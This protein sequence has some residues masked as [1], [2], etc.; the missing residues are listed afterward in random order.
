MHLNNKLC[1]KKVC[2]EV[3]NEETP[4]KYVHTF[5]KLWDFLPRLKVMS[6]STAK[7]HLALAK[8]AIKLNLSNV[9]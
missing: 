7:Y 4:T 2:R 1:L 3:E 9:Q 5:Y 8:S 6:V